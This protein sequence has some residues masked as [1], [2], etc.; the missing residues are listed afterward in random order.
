MNTLLNDLRY[1]LR[2]LSKNPGFTAVAVLTLALGIGANTAIFSVVNAVILRPLPYPH[3]ERIVTIWVTEPSGPGNLYP[4]TGPDYVDWKAQNQVFDTMGAVFVTGA[5]L[6]GTSEPLQL[7]GFEVSPE[8]LDLLGA[9][10]LAGRNFTADETVSGHDGEVILSYGLWQRA[11]GGQAGVLGSKITLDGRPYTVTG[12]VSRDFQF[13]HIWGNKPEFWIPLNLRAAEWRKSR[14]N[15][16]LWVLA[17]MKPGVPLDRAAADMK[18]VS[19]RLTQQYPVSNTGVEAKVVGLQARLTQQV[20]PAL[21]MLFA[22]VGF[23][24]L[25]AAVNVA[26]LLLA[27]A[28]SREREIA[29]RI[30]V[31]SGRWRVVRQLITESVLLFLIG[32]AAGLL[33]GSVALSLL[34]HYAPVGY[35][36]EIVSVRLDGYVFLATFLVALILGTAAGLIP[37][38]H[39]SRNDVQDSLKESAQT[40]ATS[41]NLSRSFLTA[42]E[43]ALALVMVIG[44]GLAVRS[45]VK[46]L[47]VR[48]GFDPHNVLT[49]RISLPAARYSSPAC[50]KAQG[51]CPQDRYAAFYEQLQNR[52]Q[53]LPGVASASFTSKLPLEGGSNGVVV[54]EG[55]APPKDMWSSPLVEWSTVMP[56]YFHAARIPLLRG[57]DFTAHDNNEGAPKVAII[58]RTM[59]NKFWPNQDPIGKHFAQNDTPPK[60][61][62]VVGVAG[63]VLQYGLDQTATA[64]EAYF[65]EYQGQNSS[66]NAVIR[67]AG[68]PLDELPAVRDAVH[69]LDSQLPVANPRE[70]SEVVTDS[71][72]QQRF[73]ALLLGLFAGLALVLAAVGIY[74]VI[75][76]SV[77]Q[78]THELG[79]RIALGA[80]RRELLG[81]V[82][83]EG[84][85]L[86]LAGVVVG[87]AGAW[88]LSRFLASLLYGVKPDDPL[89]FA[90]VPLILLSAALLAC[91][92]PARRA[93]KLD[94]IRA[95][96]CE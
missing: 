60:W 15:H 73:L 36:P 19:A 46:L 20:R 30:A 2:I 44:A 12:I 68:A 91:Y 8:I 41:R 94:P 71:S 3:S 76:Y 57:R 93:T 90:A 26:N 81:M 83:G 6:T 23:L 43:I 92:I 55:Q 74:G 77:A 27:K 96:R 88:G 69:E 63:D 50:E 28:V 51:D 32:G 95:L 39:A 78:R 7:Q 4:D 35:V 59:A 87:L 16:W 72:S 67:T 70:M 89:T 58:N 10:L 80:G 82:L 9:K 56:G 37:A 42:G 66:M 31:G 62:T 52:L 64:P 45:M 11:F 21:W 14:G 47:G 84:L 53:A 25:I 49:A 48:A 17:R 18:T 86:A 85:R 29:I 65:P 34:L 79:I 75:S 1:A 5:A 22:T 54:I 40:V 33:V 24:M 61:I 38:L 13:P